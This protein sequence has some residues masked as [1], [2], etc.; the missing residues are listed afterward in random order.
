M[1]KEKNINELLQM[2]YQQLVDY[3]LKKYGPVPKN[4]FTKNLTKTVGITRG[5]EGLFIHHIDEDKMI[6]L[7]N[8]IEQHP[9]VQGGFLTEKQI[10][11]I[12]NDFQQ[13]DRLVYCDLLEHLL[14]HV[15]IMEEP[16]PLLPHLNV[17]RG[18]ITNFFFPELND[19]FSGIEYKPFWKQQVIKR[20]INRK[21]EYFKIMK[22]LFNNKKFNLSLTDL[23]YF[24]PSLPFNKMIWDKNNN[25][26]LIK[27]MVDYISK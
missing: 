1:K 24:K 9:V 22:Y 13:A 3:Y 12:Y 16:K 18:G 17:G 6:L 15:K 23:S 2:S 26:K 25:K 7:S 27:E 11:M 8:K 21:D 5:K 20:V 10:K 14:L 19:I 4:Y